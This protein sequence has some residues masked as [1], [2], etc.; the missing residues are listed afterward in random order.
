LAQQIEAESPRRRTF[1]P[2]EKWTDGSTWRAKQGEDFTTSIQNFQ[3]ALHI[4]ARK[5]KKKVT[6]GAPEPGVVEFK[7]ITQA[8][9]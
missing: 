4:R 7:F 8:E 9:K 5:E 2:W 6:T 1:Y 3:T